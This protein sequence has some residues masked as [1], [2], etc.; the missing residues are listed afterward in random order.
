M[1]ST[2]TSPRAMPSV[3]STLR[4]SG[5]MPRVTGS[6]ST[7]PGSARGSRTGAPPTSIMVAPSSRALMRPSRKFIFGLPMKPATKRLTGWL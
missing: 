1:R 4:C 5:R 7:P 2:F 3:G 6:P